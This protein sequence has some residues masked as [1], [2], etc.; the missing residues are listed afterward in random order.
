MLGN[1][2]IFI[3][4]I[5]HLPMLAGYLLVTAVLRLKLDLGHSGLVRLVP[6]A[7][8]SSVGSSF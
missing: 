8:M 7:R 2:I 6:F 5:I 3:H 4:L 1:F